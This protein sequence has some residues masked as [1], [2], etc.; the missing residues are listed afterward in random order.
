[1]LVPWVEG[2][3]ERLV[4]MVV[5]GV[6]PM[7]VHLIPWAGARP[8]GVHLLPVFWTTFAAVYLCGVGTGI[9]V[10]LVAPAVNLALT[11]LPAPGSL[12][13]VAAEACLFAVYSGIFIRRWPGGRLLAPLAYLAAKATAIGVQWAVP[14]FAYTRDPFDHWVG[15]V[16]DGLAGLGVLFAI[17]VALIAFHPKTDA[18]ES[19]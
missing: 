15:S 14:A 1:M 10:G 11:G 4:L 8:L 6:I 9:V 3:R 5:A 13:L 17:N 18:W 16:T 19:E 7:A 2:W 12:V